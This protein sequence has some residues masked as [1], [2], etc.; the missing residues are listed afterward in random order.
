MSPTTTILTVLQGMTGQ[1][2]LRHV[3]LSEARMRMDGLGEA[4]FAVALAN[5]RSVGMVSEETDFLTGDKYY[6]ITPLGVAR[7]T[8]GAA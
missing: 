8:G 7:L 1:R 6:R 4:D 5:L 2:L 3:L